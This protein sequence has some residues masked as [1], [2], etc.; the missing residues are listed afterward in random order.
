MK[1]SLLKQ[2]ICILASFLVALPLEAARNPAAIQR[3]AIAVSKPSKIFFGEDGT[4]ISPELIASFKKILEEQKRFANPR[5]YIPDNLS[6]R[7]SSHVALSKIAD[8]SIHFLFKNSSIG[9]STMGRLAQDVE[10]TMIQEVDLGSSTD[11]NIKHKL[12][13]NVQA[14]T[15]EA[16]VQYEGYMKASF[17]YSLV[18]SDVGVE[19]F[20]SIDKSKELVLSHT[21]SPL[22]EDSKVAVRW[23][24]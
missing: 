20:E 18:H 5:N 10:E 9:Q 16:R 2:S 12:V 3:A 22:G 15:G 11:E 8:K 19:I 21:V 7:D 1:T 13:V 14:F 24:F 17:K 23:S 4:E 6:H